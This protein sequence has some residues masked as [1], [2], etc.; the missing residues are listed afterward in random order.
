MGSGERGGAGYCVGSAGK[1]AA[2][3]VSVCYAVGCVCSVLLFWCDGG[4]MM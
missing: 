2:S 4:N 3:F 1:G